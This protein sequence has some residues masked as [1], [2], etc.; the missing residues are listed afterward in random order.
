VCQLIPPPPTLATLVIESGY[1][2]RSRTK[3]KSERKEFWKT[4]FFF[5]H[6]FFEIFFKT[7]IC[8]H[9]HTH[10]FACSS[11]RQTTREPPRRPPPLSSSRPFIH[12]RKI[13]LN[14]KIRYIHY[15]R[16]QT[17]HDVLLF[18]PPAAL[19]LTCILHIYRCAFAYH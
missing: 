19:N 5:Q 3:K 16:T 4:T 8:T 15:V 12:P 18:V 17:T 9:T 11:R 1:S 6:T 7:Y 2:V 10:S 14:F 13:E